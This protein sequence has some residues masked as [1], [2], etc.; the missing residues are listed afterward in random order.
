MA[1][2]ELIYN[3]RLLDPERAYDGPGGLVHQNGVILDSGPGLA[4]A[5][6]GFAGVLAN[7]NGLL[8]APGLVDLRVVV[9]EPGAEHRETFRSAGRAAAAGGVTTIVVQPNTDPVIDDVSLVDFVLRRAAA[10][11]R[12]RVLPAAA[13][14]K[15]LAGDRM[16]EIGLLAEAGAIMFAH[17]D[18]P[19]TNSQLLRRAL[20]YGRAFGALFAHRPLD[21]HLS[22]GGVMHA[23]EFAGRL[24]LR[25]T[26]SAAEVIGLNRDLAL[27]ELTGGRLLV[28]MLSSAQ[29]LDPLQRA[30]QRNLDVRASVS[31][32]HLALNELDI[33]DYRT[34]AKLDPPLRAEDDRRA[35]LAGVTDGLIDVIVSGHDPQQPENKRL[36]FDE[37]AFGASA[38]ETLLPALI[39]L[40]QGGAPLEPLWRA[41]SLN[42]ANLLGLPQ[43]R[44][45]RG[46]PADLVLVDSGSPFRCE[47]DRLLSKSRNTPF[48]GRLLQGQ[49]I[50][51]L[52]GG[53]TIYSRE[54]P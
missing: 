1:A 5:P 25:G 11:T 22:K 8:L 7:A 54:N 10:R 52:V 45:S 18:A 26:P 19:I 16:A 38:L 31:V 48:D 43:G 53:Q 28:D 44:L 24:G 35:L 20:S 30:K 40:H 23:G 51:T 6:E 42:P 17:G 47:A 46:A 41:A 2:P 29:S 4:S 33:G 3:A 15:G 21:P 13:I 39:S 34:F 12:V 9:G 50:R 36:P 37:A 27:A 49:V 32:H 14:T